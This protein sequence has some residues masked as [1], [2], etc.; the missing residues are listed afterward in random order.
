MAVASS[1]TRDLI[2]EGAPCNTLHHAIA[3]RIDSLGGAGDKQVSNL[4]EP[5]FTGGTFAVRRVHCVFSP[6]S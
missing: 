5:K 1:L 4:H 3:P 6:C 2:D